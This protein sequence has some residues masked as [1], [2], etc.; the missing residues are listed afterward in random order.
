MPRRPWLWLLLI[1]LL[2]LAGAATVIWFTNLVPGAR[3]RIEALWK[4]PAPPARPRVEKKAG[5]QPAPAVKREWNYF[6][7]IASTATQ[8]AATQFANRYRRQ[9]ISTKVETEPLEK[10]RRKTFRVWIGPFHSAAAA[11][12]AKD[13]L[14]SSIPG[15]A[16]I[17]SMR[18]TPDEDPDRKFLTIEAAIAPS[19]R[20]PAPAQ[21]GG[22]G[23]P[24]PTTGFSVVAGSYTT[25]AAAVNANTNL[26][27][28]RLPSF[29]TSRIVDGKTWYSVVLGPF[30][31]RQQALQYRE[32]VNKAGVTGSYILENSR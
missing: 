13:S 10:G 15:D 31:T 20:T 18:I 9:G 4:R 5:E 14:A 28:R 17:D 3:Q 30:A 1:V 26:T 8:S 25:Q 24:M 16:F 19:Q 6:L 2:V 22:T 23:R 29:V 21:K 7:Q 27:G 11:R 32:L 12:A